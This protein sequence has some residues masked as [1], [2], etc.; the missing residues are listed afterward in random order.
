[1]SLSFPL[2]LLTICS[3]EYFHLSGFL[4]FLLLILSLWCFWGRYKNACVD[5][6]SGKDCTEW[7]LS[8]RDGQ[9]LSHLPDVHQRL[10]TGMTFCN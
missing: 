8:E 4:G 7:D 6:E 9:L 2:D 1:M 5:I 10:C 3:Q